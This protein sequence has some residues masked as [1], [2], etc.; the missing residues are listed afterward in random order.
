MCLIPNNVPGGH[1]IQLTQT[2]EALRARGVDVEVVERVPSSATGFDL[3]HGLG[4]DAATVRHFRR[5][6]IPVALSSIYAS[7]RYAMALDGH[8]SGV[9]DALRRGR[10]AMSL[11]TSVARLQHVPKMEALL[12]RQTEHR[13]AF[14]SADL[15]LP[16]A[17]GEAHLIRRELGVS[18]PIRIVPNGVDASL[19]RA[20]A[21]DGERSGV[22]YV[23]R[24]DEWKNQL[25]LIRALAGS[26]VSLTIVGPV[27]P[28]HERYI[29]RCRAEAGE[30]VTFV[31]GLPQEDLA[32]YYQRASVHALPSWYETTG[33]VS[34]EAALCGC[35][36]V[37]TNR[38]HAKEY[39]GDQAWY[40]DPG[41]LRS[42]RAAVRG[43]LH[44]D[45][46]PKLRD[47][48][49]EKY[50]WE[51]AAEATLSAYADLVDGLNGL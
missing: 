9:A 14:E 50:T 45:E 11:A 2:A 28:H 5:Q 34:L 22:L 4:L 25:A 10:T 51:R 27:H 26:G 41:D 30:W 46:R 6:R 43:A 15:L 17:R 19:F 29:D 42:I 39:L 20:P 35:R 8:L 47:R 40:C 48:I 1:K 23:G 38:G 33:L 37:S 16:N 7:Y 49:L 32:D 13:L 12:A 3:V 31:L 44:D 24:I 21:P 18:T 36:I